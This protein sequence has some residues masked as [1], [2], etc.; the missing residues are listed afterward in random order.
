MSDIEPT[1]IGIDQQDVDIP[2]SENE[3]YNPPKHV[4]L[5]ELV[6]NARHVT[7]E[8]PQAIVDNF[9]YI[10][11]QMYEQLID[12]QPINF[13]ITKQSL[14]GNLDTYDK[15]LN[16]FNM[17]ACGYRRQ[18]NSDNELRNKYTALMNLKDMLKEFEG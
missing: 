2:Q 14:V 12:G 8:T 9:Y 7:D 11:S 6:G 10:A 1:D 15:W 17:R 3:G 16:S 4:S 13:E 5:A 18:M